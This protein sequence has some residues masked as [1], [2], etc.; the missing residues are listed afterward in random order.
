MN[1]CM[2]AEVIEEYYHTDLHFFDG[3]SASDALRKNCTLDVWVPSLSLALEYQGV[4][5]YHDMRAI[6]GDLGRQRRRDLEKADACRRA[7]ITL[8]AVPYWWN[9]SPEDLAATIARVRPDLLKT[10]P[11]LAEAAHRGIP[12]NDPTANE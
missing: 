1:E 4:Q 7:G 9:Q 2:N 6:G 11:I 12:I 5:H 8:V 10:H 3:N